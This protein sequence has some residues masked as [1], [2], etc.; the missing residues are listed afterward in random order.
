M[1]LSMTNL[2]SMKIPDSI[3]KAIASQKALERNCL[4][5]LSV[6]KCLLSEMQTTPLHTYSDITVCRQTQAWGWGGGKQ[7][8]MKH[9]ILSVG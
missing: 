6:H 8:K 4:K 9:T 2:E 5:C 1:R 7:P 3:C